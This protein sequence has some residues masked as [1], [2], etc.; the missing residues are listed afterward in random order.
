M[1]SPKPID[2]RG[3][4]LQLRLT[5]REEDLLILLLEGYSMH[6]IAKTLHIGEQTVRNYASKLYGKLEVNSRTELLVK[7]SRMLDKEP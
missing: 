6:K 2:T 5:N 4:W 7:Y 3:Q 1:N